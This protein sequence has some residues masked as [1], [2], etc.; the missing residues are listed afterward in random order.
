MPGQ[1]RVPGGDEWMWARGQRRLLPDRRGVRWRGWERLARDWRSAGRRT[2]PGPPSR[3]VAV[4]TTN[5]PAS[6]APGGQRRAPVEPHRTGRRALERADLDRRRT[7]TRSMP[8][9][10]VTEPTSSGGTATREHDAPRAGR[11]PAPRCT[12]GRS[13]VRPREAR[14]RGT[15]PPRG[16]SRR[17]ARSRVRARRR[18]RS[19]LPP[20]GRVRRRPTRARATPTDEASHP[21]RRGVAVA[22]TCTGGRR[23]DRPH[24]AA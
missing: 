19:A 23:R 4:S 9:S 8:G 10:G 14:R 3:G 2:M 6:T 7:G 24:R 18:R 15:C 22:V 5:V 16:R 17:R 21:A 13:P 20:A 11:R 12:A 1:S